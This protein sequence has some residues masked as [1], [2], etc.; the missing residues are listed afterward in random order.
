MSYDLIL[1]LILPKF[2]VGCNREGTWLCSKCQKDI[3]PVLAQKC[4]KCGRLSEQGLYCPRCRYDS[5]KTEVKGKK[6]PQ[7]VKRRQPLEGIISAAYF[8]E[9]P[10][11]EMIHNFK[12]N[13]VLDLKEKL[14]KMLSNAYKQSFRAK[15]GI[16]DEYRNWHSPEILLASR[17][18]AQDDN[19]TIITFVPLHPARFAR[20]GYNQAEILAEVV[21][22]RLKIPSLNLLRK[23][24][25]TKRQVGMVGRKRRQNLKGVFRIRNSKKPEIKGKKIIIIDDIATTGATLNECAKVLK[26]A[27]AKEVWGLVIALG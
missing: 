23:V 11:K 3:L 21:S 9:G 18:L 16:T 10:T 14:G 13:S 8:E 19:N 20:R 24:K 1:D 22:Q 7:V 15:R 25:N 2:C 4:P 6:K 12:Y 27:G 5:F 26:E 17:R